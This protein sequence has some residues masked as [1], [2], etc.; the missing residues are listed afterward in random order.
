MINYSRMVREQVLEGIKIP[1]NCSN[2]NM[3]CSL[4]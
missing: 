2:M 1:E 4:C 3:Q